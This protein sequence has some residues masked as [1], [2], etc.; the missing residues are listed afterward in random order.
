MNVCKKE[1]FKFIEQLPDGE[2]IVRYGIMPF[3]HN[4]NGEELVTFTSSQYP[5]KPSM[6]QISRSILRFNM[7]MQDM[8][9]LKPAVSP[10]LSV[11]ATY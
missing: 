8:D 3:G 2:W 5:R 6:E 4:L 11:Y 10:D 1:G 9:L 7:A